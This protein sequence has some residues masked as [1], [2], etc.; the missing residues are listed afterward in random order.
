MSVLLLKSTQ[1]QLK[2][3]PE[4]SQYCRAFLLEQPR[5]FCVFYLSFIDSIHSIIIIIYISSTLF[6][7]KLL[8]KTLTKDR[9][10][11]LCTFT[12]ISPFNNNH[13]IFSTRLKH[14]PECNNNN[15]SIRGSC[16]DLQTDLQQRTRC[17]E[18]AQATCCQEIT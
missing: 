10:E 4:T 7:N 14:L 8:I 12:V 2:C 13:V 5:L 6:Q 16:N 15:I 9:T 3:N 17:S 18:R 11:F 1:C